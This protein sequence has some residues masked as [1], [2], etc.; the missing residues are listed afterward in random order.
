MHFTQVLLFLHTFAVCPIN[1][2][3]RHLIGLGMY[4]STLTLYHPMSTS[5]G[6]RCLSKVRAIF[7]FGVLRL[8]VG[9][10]LLVEV[11]LYASVTPCSL[12]FATTSVSGTDFSIGS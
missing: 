6:R 11:N 8:L 2:Q 12:R 4:I 7:P 9:L 10:S 1:W 3:L 5:F